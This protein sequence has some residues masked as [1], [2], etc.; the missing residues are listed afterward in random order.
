[1]RIKIPTIPSFDIENDIAG[2]VAGTDEAGRGPLCGPVVAAACVMTDKNIPV[3]IA[4]SK[5]MTKSQRETAYEWITK[6][7]ILAVGMCSPNEIDKINILQASLLAMKRAIAALPQKPDYVLV[8]GNKM[9]DGIVGRAIV[10]GDGKSMSIAAASI[11]AKVTRDRIMSELAKQY[12]QYGW[13][14]NA[15]YP[16]PAHLAAISEYGINEHYRK[17][18]APVKNIMGE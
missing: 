10:K 16:T 8:D 6:N 15:G 11:I 5:Q 3:L 17:T 4:D 12:P 13:D 18:F 9:P 2:I 7:T 1:M 14:K